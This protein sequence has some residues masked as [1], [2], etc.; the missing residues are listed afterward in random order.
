[1]G[2][3]DID[4]K[5]IQ[6]MNERNYAS[7]EEGT[8]MI[9]EIE[10]GF[11]ADM[12]ILNVRRP[13]AFLRVTEHMKEII[14][15]IQTIIDKGYA[16]QTPTGVYFDVDKAGE[17]YAKLLQ[18]RTRRT[19]ESTSN[20][21]AGGG[22]GNIVED[23]EA[24]EA[25]TIAEAVAAE[26]ASDAS[27]THS[28]KDP[29]DFVL[30]KAAKAGEPVWDSPWG[31]GRPG[32]H[33]E[34]SA[35]THSYFGE[36]IDIHSGGIDLKFPHH[37][38]EMAQCEAHNGNP[39]WVRY[40]LHTGHLYIRGRKMSK[41]LKNF[42]SVRD[43]LEANMSTN[44][45]DDFRI[46]CLQNKYNAPLHFSAD[47]IEEAAAFRKKLQSLGAILRAVKKQQVIKG[48]PSTSNGN[49]L[50]MNSKKETKSSHKLRQK[51]HWCK[52]AVDKAFADD[53]STPIAMKAITELTSELHIYA[54]EV[55]SASVSDDSID[56]TEEH[57]IEIVWT[58][59]AYIG[60]MVNLVGLTDAV[61]VG[62]S[63]GGSMSA[64][65][66]GGHSSGSGV[67]GVAAV[68][69]MLWFRSSVRHNALGAIKPLKKASK[70][71]AN[72]S[73]NPSKQLPAE[74]L[75][76]AMELVQ[77]SA[78]GVNEIM[79]LSDE[80]RDT[81]APDELGIDVQDLGSTTSTWK[82]SI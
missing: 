21:G 44:P 59:Q 77:Q 7:W 37:C 31:P 52:D 54:S 68:D 50:K 4:D 20:N 26:A 14:Q 55:L 62:L 40:W 53:F 56:S 10:H 73:K 34:C 13:D 47:R 49:N 41:S 72:G 67:N 6:R 64:E 58:V 11:F 33:I 35:V 3:T 81:K 12:D 1:M 60:K 39:D 38:N 70:L 74:D 18:K 19:G 15:Y 42:I 51:L 25:N 28:K 23:S 65:E 79:Q 46:M 24:L 17:S 32:W 29:R 22:T 80:L 16:Y 71:L 30:W 61:D 69:L 78:N 8:V 36:S 9:R 82:K 66:E 48:E 2:V 5:I 57:P 76:T 45:G 27:S 43:Y 63:S 75:A